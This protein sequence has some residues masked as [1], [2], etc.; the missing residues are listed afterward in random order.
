MPPL[1]LSDDQMSIIEQMAA[2]LAPADRPAY[3]E[4]VAPLLAD[5]EIAMAA[6]PGR[7]SKRRVSYGE[8]RRWRGGDRASESTSVSRR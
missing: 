7:R 3:L 2:P 4:R 6:S 1:A 8:R 5:V